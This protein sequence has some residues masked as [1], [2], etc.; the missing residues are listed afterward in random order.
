MADMAH[1]CLLAAIAHLMEEQF[2]TYV[3]P[4]THHY[5]HLNPYGSHPLT[6]PLFSSKGL[7]IVH[8]GAAFDRVERTELVAGS[9]DALKVLHV[10]WQDFM[11]GNCSKCE[12]CV[13]TMATLDLVGARERARTFDWSIY[14]L[15]AVAA[16][17]LPTESE[18]GFFVEIVHAARARGDAA[19]AQA[20]QTALASSRRRARRIHVADTIRLF[21]V[22]NIKSYRLTRSV[23]NGLKAV[24]DK[25]QGRT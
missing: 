20:A 11:L 18:R 1:G 5:G 25:A 2:D 12:K 16:A 22:R 24:R 14:S 21:T 17:W 3:I 19:L 4:A 8:D 6:D 15:A 9:S 13:R 10:C 7:R 23:W